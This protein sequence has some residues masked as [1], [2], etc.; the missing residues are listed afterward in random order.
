[1]LAVFE[2]S[3]LSLHELEKQRTWGRGDHVLNVVQCFEKYRI[4]RR[5]LLEGYVV[6]FNPL[7]ALLWSTAT[8]AFLDIKNTL[9]YHFTFLASLVIV[10]H[11]SLAFHLPCTV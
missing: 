1:V 8:K 3:I 10:C 2:L 9:S 4:Q 7:Q 11:M 6:I 5:N